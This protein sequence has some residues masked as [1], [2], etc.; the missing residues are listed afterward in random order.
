MQ[1]KIGIL[2]MHK[3][4]NYGSF[5][6]AFAL[7][8][9]LTELFNADVYFIEIRKGVNILNTTNG[10]LRKSRFHKLVNLLFKPGDFFQ[11][12]A[13]SKFQRKFENKYNHNYLPLLALA[14]APPNVYDLVIIGS[15]EVFN[16][17][18]N[19]PWGFSTQLFGDYLNSKKII[20]YAAS[21]GYTTLERIT[22]YGLEERIDHAL[23]KLNDISVRDDNS[24]EIIKALMNVAPKVHADPVLIY[25]FSNFI[26]PDNVHHQNYILIYAKKIYSTSE[27]NAIRK[28]AACKNKKLICI[29]CHY[30]WCDHVII[31]ESPFDVLAYF[32][33]A[34]FIV[35]DT[36][37][38][39][40]FSVISCKKFVT[41]IRDSN[42]QKLTYLLE[43]LK[44]QTRIVYEMKH[45]EKILDTTIDYDSVRELIDMEKR[46]SLL[47]FEKYC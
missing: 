15:D 44:L 35:T 24:Y 39:T 2:T 9:I 27:I 8:Q 30:S 33:M 12:L 20:S 42:K 11:S 43:T 22:E 23:K 4:T 13:K 1:K 16:C 14:K 5:L 29:A 26:K 6:Q 46:K 19:A 3:V 7:K 37:H 17:T 38:G 47:Y 40:I 21:F 10:T 34:D 18:Q 25:D 36:F 45:L 41:I 31:P 32:S 28:F